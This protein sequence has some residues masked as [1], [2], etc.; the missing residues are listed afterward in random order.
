MQPGFESATDERTRQLRID[1]LVDGGKP[2]PTDLPHRGKPAER[3]RERGLIRHSLTAV[4]ILRADLVEQE[5]QIDLGVV[6]RVGSGFSPLIRRR[7]PPDQAVIERCQPIGIGAGLF[8]LW[9][10]SGLCH[11]DGVAGTSR[12]RGVPST[13]ATIPWEFVWSPADALPDAAGVWPMPALAL[14]R[15]PVDSLGA[16][17]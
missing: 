1:R 6:D 12:D 15:L 4:A 14:Q 5:K 16:M 13:V 3:G 11:R 2:A 17:T 8:R 9:E 7:S 10:W